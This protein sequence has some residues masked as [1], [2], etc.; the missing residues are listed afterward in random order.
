MDWSTEG[1]ITPANFRWE[2]RRHSKKKPQIPTLQKLARS[3]ILKCVRLRGIRK[4][5]KE[6]PLPSNLV[7]YITTA[8][9]LDD[10]EVQNCNLSRVKRIHCL[11]PTRFLTDGS[12]VI[13]KCI[14]LKS[15]DISGIARLVEIWSRVEHKHITKVLAW[16][17]DREAV[18]VVFNPIPK[19][20]HEL[21]NGYRKVKLQVP[22][23]FVW[24]MLYQTSDALLYLQKRQIV[25]TELKSKTI[26]ITCS[27]DILLHN[28]LMYT[29][30]EL[31]L[32]V[33]IDV[34][35]SFYGIY[36]APERIQGRGYSPKQ[37]SWALGCI[38]Y[39]MTYL[40]P[41]F[42]LQPG[43]TVFKMLNKIVNG[44]SPPRLEEMCG[45]SPDLMNL[46]ISCFM[47]EPRLRPTVKDI[48]H[49]AK[50]RFKA[51]KP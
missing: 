35:D 22:E 24:K 17:K 18:G 1:E 45:Y 11:Y 4:A 14:H 13:L 38:A 31:E 28:I 5:Q 36:V 3:V 43:E 50:E 21:V 39:E 8:F 29:P 27:G 37:D 44:V 9:S 2:T 15:Q 49:I 48:Q 34:K 32:N 30:S 40:E 51:T 6:L 16:F 20:L 12:N 19:T 33:C 23:W 42:C 25:H 46:M 10:F 26:S 41:A 7:D 47:P